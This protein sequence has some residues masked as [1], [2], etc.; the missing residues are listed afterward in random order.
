LVLNIFDELKLNLTLGDFYNS[1]DSIQI[2]LPKSFE[3]NDVSNMRDLFELGIEP[4]FVFWSSYAPTPLQCPF[5]WKKIVIEP[6][7]PQQPQPPQ[8][9]K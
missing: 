1:L 9:L 5:L 4:K 2:S 8:P 6:P 3:F 7:K